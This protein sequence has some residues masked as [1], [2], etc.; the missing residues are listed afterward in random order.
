[1]AANRE[2]DAQQTD[3]QHT[4]TGADEA[5]AW[6]ERLGWT[7][8]LTADDPAARTTALTRLTESRHHIEEA[9]EELNGMW[10]RKSP[11]GSTRHYRETELT[12]ASVNYAEARSRSLPEGLW[13]RPP[14]TDITTWPGLPYALRF[15]EWEAKHPQEWTRL[16]K[17]WG[18]K[19]RLL[20]DL[21]AAHHDETVTARLTD[22][23]ER[24]VARP[25]RCKDL[26]YVRIARAVDSD[27]LRRRL[28]AATESEHS[29]ARQH[30]AYVLWMLDHPSVP[31]TRHSW[32]TWLAQE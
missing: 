4:G 16:A 1:M 18:T 2:A 3:T 14:G 15:L 20:R 31:N 22:L 29:W 13:D 12:R 27:E 21:A 5:A 17:A 6:R 9:L 26:E 23:V 11:P 8:G 10:R 32:R 30:G 28:A 24:I 7:H 19:E 25:Y